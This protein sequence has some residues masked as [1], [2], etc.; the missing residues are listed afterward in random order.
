MEKIIASLYISISAQCPECE[1]NIE[2]LTDTDLN[3]D[4]WLMQQA[5]PDEGAW[6][7]AHE[8]FECVV[9]CPECNT[10]LHLKDIDW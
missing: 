4:G 10:K 5:C 6:S 8:K 7:D 1:K 9:A 3:D 2:L